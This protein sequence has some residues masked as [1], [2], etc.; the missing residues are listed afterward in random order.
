MYDAQMLLLSAHEVS[1]L[2]DVTGEALG[3]KAV[4]DTRT[5][6]MYLHYTIQPGGRTQQLVPPEYS[7]MAYVFQGEAHFSDSPNVVKDGQMALF[8]GA[9]RFVC[10]D[11]LLNIVNFILRV[12][13]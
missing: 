13:R 5:P 7:V 9:W 3:V 11:A 2:T 6:I 8:G 12:V 10:N 1:Q 4:I